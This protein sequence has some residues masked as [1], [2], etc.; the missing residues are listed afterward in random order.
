MAAV[1]GIKYFW[2]ASVLE[3]FAV[4]MAG[5][6]FSVSGTMM[7]H[8][9]NYALEQLRLAHSLADAPLRELAVELFRFFERQPPAG[10]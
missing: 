9:G 4:R 5:H 8:D 3:A 6:G 2:P 1:F 7:K 10:A